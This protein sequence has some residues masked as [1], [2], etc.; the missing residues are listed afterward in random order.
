MS[1]RH[2]QTVFTS[3]IPEQ[4]GLSEISSESR[5]DRMLAALT[6]QPLQEVDDTELAVPAKQVAPVSFAL[7]RSMEGRPNAA[8]MFTSAYGREDAPRIAFQTARTAAINSNGKV[9]YIHA[10]ERDGGFFKEFEEQIPMTLGDFLNLGG[11]KVLPFVVLEDSGLVCAYLRG[12]EECLN[13][14]GIK[15]LM[16]ALRSRFDLIVIG[17]DK[18]LSGGASIAFS[19]LVDG[20]ILVTEAERTRV[21]VA[22]RLKRAVEDSGGAVIGAILNN[23]KYHIPDWIYRHLYGGDR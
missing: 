19:D 14:S 12:A 21:P 17:G 16:T 10:S 18:A 8:I 22:Q 7:R 6:T 20:T 23:R 15:A 3:G 2:H 5:E 4:A 9:L 11:G 13:S 1:R